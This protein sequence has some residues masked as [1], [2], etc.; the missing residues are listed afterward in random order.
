MEN[1]Q[2]SEFNLSKTTLDAISKK[3]FSET[4]EIQSA[5]IPLI[6]EQNNDVIGIA[7]TGTGKT[8]AFGL[9]LID[10]IDTNNKT[11]QAIILCPTRELALQVSAEIKTYSGNRKLSLTTI[12]GGSS[13]SS[14][15]KELKQGTDIVVGTP[16]RVVD[17]LNRGDLDLKKV[18]HFVLDE[19]DEMLKMGFIEDIE[20]ILGSS[21][22]QKKV[23]LF[24]ATM[25]QR[26]KDLSKT[27][28]NNQKVVEV[29]KKKEIN[30]LIEKS[31][32]KAKQS[33]KFDVLTNIIEG[34]DFF[35]GI[36]FCKTKADVDEITQ[37]LKKQKHAVD[38]IHGDIAQNKREK[39]L[40]NFKN[41]KIA[42]LVATDVA[43]RGIDV[44]NLSHIVNYHIPEDSHTFTHRIGRTGRAGN[45]GK[46]ISLVTPAEM[47]K[48]SQFEKELQIKIE[49][50]K[51][52]KQAVEKKKLNKKIES[53]GKIIDKESFSQNS[54]VVNSLLEKYPAE[55]IISALLSEE[56][57]TTSNE[58]TRLFIAKGKM[59][60]INARELIRFV[61]KEIKTQ[62]GDVDDI[63]VCEKFSFMTINNNEAEK[64][65]DHFKQKNPRKPLVEIAQ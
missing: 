38:C 1:K 5:I 40:S 46:A 65:V 61:E 14:Q 32:Y 59:D 53:I 34:E 23:Y 10:L 11:P 60:K 57:P 55:K 44:N 43:A 16:G 26:I 41:Q 13:I 47:R 2:F 52:D 50:Q 35:Y 20:Y 45:T 37:K 63:K 36:I 42:I 54:E 9:P 6:L 17:L 48:I 58:K 22:K 62:L 30:N 8:A 33:E 29:K 51:I 64:V 12:Y 4:S 31:F 15:V 56:Q 25:P 27:Y 3:G 19:A 28:M 24:S 18:K 39:I 7:Q 21:S 49:S